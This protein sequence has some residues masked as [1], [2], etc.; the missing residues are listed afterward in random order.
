MRNVREFLQQNIVYLDGGT[1]TLLQEA[2]LPL[3]E[4]PERWNITHADVIQAIHRGYFNAGSNIVCT[5]TFGANRLKFPQAELAEIVKAAVENARM[6]AASSCGAQEKFVALDIGPS[7]K[8]L[9]PYGD[10]AF[11][12]AVALFA[13]TVKLGVQYGVDLIYIETMSDS[14]ETK[15]A[16]LAAKENCDLPVFVSCAYGADGK[17]MTG[18]SPA[19]MVAMLE[20]MGADVIGVNCSVGPK[21]MQSV[22]DELLENASVPV[23]VK[24]NAGLPI[25][26]GGNT[27]YD[28]DEKEFALLVAEFVRKGARLVGG[29]C[30]TTPAYIAELVVRTKGLEP[31]CI[32]KKE[33]TCVS[34]YTHAVYFDEPVLIG[35]RINPT[36]KKRFKQALK[37]KDTA[38]VLAE[39]ISQQEK[40]AH[41]L[42]VNVG[43]P[44]IDERAELPRYIEE[45]QAVI[46]LPLQIDTSDPV[47][48][49]RAMRI[50]NGKP[51]VNSVNGKKE[52]MDGIFPLVK[53]YGGVVIA[54]TLDEKGIPDS[55]EERVQIAER[56]V[57]EGAKYGISKKDIIVDPLAMTISADKNAAKVTL[58]ALRML[59]AKGLHTSL[60]VSNVSFGLP[61]RETVNAAFFA[62]ALQEGLSAAIINP[63]SVEMR[64]TY[65]AYLALQGL[66]ENCG[67][68]IRFATE[69][70][71]QYAPVESTAVKSVSI[72]TKDGTPLKTAIVKGLSS[73]AAEACQELLKT[74]SALE[75]INGE[76]V[77]ALDE[78]GKAY[79]EKR[80]YLPQLL[81]SAEGAKS[82]FE[83]IRLHMIASGEAQTKKC[84]IVLATVKGDIHDIGKNIVGTLLENYGFDVLD[85]GRDVSPEKIVEEVLRTGAPAV[86]LSALMT[87]TVPSMAETI[88]LLREKAPNVKIIVGGAVLTEEYAKEI[89]AD[90]YGKDALQAVRFMEKL[91]A[92][93]CKN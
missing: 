8:L 47:A 31:A 26:D 59:K 68:Y 32:T 2:G 54:L 72:E 48:M 49:E 3:G 27:R 42:D 21:Q 75:I 90:G 69:I 6:A 17:L 74:Q 89:G 41:I 18:A 43:S 62:L 38:Y 39:G 50:Y 78:V 40:G 12:D 71:P 10:F 44:E 34:S 66:D 16:L 57:A 24:P 25:T 22:V 7:G 82:A 86:G 91:Y 20:G 23:L 56:I 51:L 11:E 65:H 19:A 84:K 35:E 13:E 1:G 83:K 77:P 64:K 29:C 85:L 53:K 92:D 88:K 61:S 46:N 4:L 87:T 14:Y 73:V 79:E 15:A 33:R 30:G 9:K 52:S 45:L 60:G 63:N 28:I 67:G 93:L 70:I 81:M 37:E 80:A 58:E 36:G 5:N 76:I 55:A